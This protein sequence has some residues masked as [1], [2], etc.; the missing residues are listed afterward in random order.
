VAPVTAHPAQRPLRVALVVLTSGGA[1]GGFAK[2]LRCLLPRLRQ[3]SRIRELR[4]FAPSGLLASLRERGVI[5]DGE[6]PASSGGAR[7]LSSGVRLMRPDVVF[8][9]SARA[10]PAVG[11]PQVIM[12]RNMEPFEAP[13]AGLGWSGALR[14]AGRL[15]A[16]RRACRRASRV[17][18]VSRHVA[19]VLE[20]RLRVPGDKLAVIYHGVDSPG[21]DP[22]LRPA[23]A[24]QGDLPFLFS[25]G[26]IRPARG[27]DDLVEAL[28][29]GGA[30]APVVWIAGATDPDAEAYARQ[31]RL[32]LRRSGLEDRM[33]FLGRIGEAEMRWCF[34][35]ASAFVMTSRA[36]AC[37]NTALEALA[38][39]CVVVSTDH[40]PMPEVLGEGARYYR[41]RDAK[42]LAE[43][44]RAACS[45]P[46]ESREAR[47]RAA[48]LRA[49]EFDWGST[50]RGTIDVLESAARAQD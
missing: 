42:D 22:G 21:D 11:A 17:I 39:G 24:P 14:N 9:P 41:A 19:A 15:L 37:P 33:R 27:L 26:S 32:R 44:I 6:G 20:R 35:N 29:L 18:A 46:P 28:P 43:Q 40:P 1:S 49:A 10:L 50:A 3:D 7:E 36:E 30:A 45:A 47:S 25:A 2:H 12:V 34:R 16:A 13:F 5:A 48:R 4:L 23:S 31:L 8:V 38:H